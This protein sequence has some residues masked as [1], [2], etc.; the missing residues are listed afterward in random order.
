VSINLQA[1]DNFLGQCLLVFLVIEG[2]KIFPFIARASRGSILYKILLNV[3][4][5]LVFS[6]LVRGTGGEM[7][8]GQG[9]SPLVLTV[10][11]GSLIT[12]GLHRLKKAFER[13]SPS[14]HHWE[15]KHGSS[16]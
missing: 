9:L 1:W 11:V 3:A 8:Q 10:I 15:A 5:N 13:R 4:V 6:I 12:A 2:L 14:N 16:D 7:I